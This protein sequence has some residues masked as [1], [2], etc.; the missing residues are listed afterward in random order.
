MAE[1]F[2]YWPLFV[3]GFVVTILVAVA[4]AGVASAVAILAGLAQVSSLRLLNV[5]SHIYVEVFRGS[6]AIVQLYVFFYV[7]PF[8]GIR[9]SSYLVAILGLGLNLGAYASQAVRAGIQ[10]IPDGQWDSGYTCGLGYWGTVRR[11]VLPQALVLMLP[12]LGNELVEA[13]K[14]TP[15]VSLVL[16]H[17]LT[18]NGQLVVQDTGKTVTVYLLL[19]VLYLVLTLPVGW[20][21]TWLERRV[22]TRRHVEVPADANVERM[23]V[24]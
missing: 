24:A 16:V 3:H 9:L 11:V 21:T 7:L 10:A 17:D 6:S 4:I 8:V 20:L 2:Q 19:L 18:F 22:S 5:I 12:A 14:L 23:E 13:I 1:V 15:I